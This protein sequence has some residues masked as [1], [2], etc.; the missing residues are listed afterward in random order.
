[1][2][3]IDRV[4][5]NCD[6]CGDRSFW[7][8]AKEQ[9]THA[10]IVCCRTCGLLYTNPRYSDDQINQ[11]YEDEFDGDPGSNQ[12]IIENSGIPT[13][14]VEAE[15]TRCLNS[16]SLL[17]KHL[18][19][20]SKIG[21]SLRFGLGSMPYLLRQEGALMYGLDYFE[22]NRNHAALTYQVENLK[23]A[24]PVNFHLLSQH[25]PQK[26]DFIEGLTIH[27]ASHVLSIR[28][29]LEEIY[30]LLNPNGYLFLDEKEIFQPT[31]FYGNSIFDSGPH[32]FYFL[33]KIMLLSYLESTGFE[34][35]KCQ[36]NPYRQTA[37]KHIFIVARKK[38][39]LHQYN[40]QIMQRPHYARSVR[41][42]TKLLA[43]AWPLKRI[44][45]QLP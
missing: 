3:K 33:S 30:K 7:L 15:M 21:L 9:K 16:L 32:H 20:K 24:S 2:Q 17:K 1:M 28:K 27:T 29:L 40:S 35:V 14:K 26:F 18:N 38:T 8:I 42:Q 31:R 6:L 13:K 11:F 44:A 10:Q 23:L 19:P 39:S 12:K 37:F 41:L 4:E 34:I 5:T 43:L 22:E 36:I 25:F 45:Q